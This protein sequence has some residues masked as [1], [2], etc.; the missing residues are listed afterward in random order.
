M[1]L[2]TYRYLFKTNETEQ[3]KIGVK[4]VT[5]TAEN[6]AKLEEKISSD[7]SVLSCMKEYV[8]ETDLSFLGMTEII[9]K[10]EKENVE[11]VD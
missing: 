2:F 10:E 6:L 11:T 7:S 5:D 8:C 9:K 3:D 4:I 1:K